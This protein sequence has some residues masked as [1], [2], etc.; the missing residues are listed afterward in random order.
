MA[1]ANPQAEDMS[2]KHEQMK[3]TLEAVK[4][5]LAYMKVNQKEKHSVQKKRNLKEDSRNYQNMFNPWFLKHHLWMQ[6][7]HSPYLPRVILS[8]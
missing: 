7:M 8:F 4:Y 3:Q 6:K 2:D 1:H 5:D